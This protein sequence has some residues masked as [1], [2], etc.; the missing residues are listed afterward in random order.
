MILGSR[1]SEGSTRTATYRPY[2]GTS[3][4]L[5]GCAHLSVGNCVNWTGESFLTWSRAAVW[6][7]CLGPSEA[8]ARPGAMPVTTRTLQSAIRTA[9]DGRFLRSMDGQ[10]LAGAP[11]CKR[12]RKPGACP[13]GWGLAAYPPGGAG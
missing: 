10:Y 5:Q 13:A 8:R 12:R 4:S 1:G 11:I 7:G 3:V 9:Q 6:A 2:H